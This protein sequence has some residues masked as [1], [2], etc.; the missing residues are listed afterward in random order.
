M[1]FNKLLFFHLA[2]TELISQ[3]KKNMHVTVFGKLWLQLNQEKEFGHEPKIFV[4]DDIQMI[5][6]AKWPSGQDKQ[7]DYTILFQIPIW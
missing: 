1:C 4:S 6:E 3:D 7:D 5:F 2:E